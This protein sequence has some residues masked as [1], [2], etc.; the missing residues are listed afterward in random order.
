MDMRIE[1][2]V[3][4]DFNDVLIK[5][6]R[7][8][9]V[10]RSEVE[11]TRE[12]KLLNCEL[13]KNKPWDAGVP[14]VAANMTTVASLKVAEALAKHNCWTALHKF[15]DLAVLEK[16]F[17]NA[18]GI[19]H[20]TFY[21]M[22]TTDDDYQK[23]RM[24][25]KLAVPLPNI[26]IDIANGYRQS[27]VKF[28]REIRELYPQSVMMAGNVCTPEMVIELLIEG[29]ADLIKVGIG[30]GKICKTRF[31]THIGVPQLSAII[32]C[33][34]A[35]HGVGGLICSD[36]GIR[37]PGHV[38]AAIGGGA[39][40][41]M[42]GGYFSGHDENEGD[43]TYDEQG[44]K[45]GMIFYGMSS[46][47]AMNK[48]YGGKPSYRASEGGTMEIPYKGSINATIE[49]ILGGLRSTCTYVGTDKLKDLS[50][51]TTFVRV[52]RIHDIPTK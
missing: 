10:S 31:V 46:D 23:L 42:I 26:C 48:Y 27:F 28:V 38:A 35:A 40:M 7:S 20:R 14:I 6:K 16:F 33:A 41:V 13:Y 43:F 11:L 9:A 2:E 37:Q 22:G 44:N 8:L 49:E 32:E 21:T 39:D 19:N 5:P 52:N 4:L 36:G 12:F 17:K 45:K 30:G 29:K 25:F 51:C 47:T 1:N 15:Y 18:E 50:K 3:K 34:D 24:L